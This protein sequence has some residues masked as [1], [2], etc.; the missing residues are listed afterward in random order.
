MNNE[1]ECKWLQIFVKIEFL[2]KN[3]VNLYNQLGKNS[4]N[5]H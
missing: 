5:I 1:K 4:D 2:K 3:I